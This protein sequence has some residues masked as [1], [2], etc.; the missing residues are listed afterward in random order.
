[1]RSFYEK[2][3]IFFSGMESILFYGIATRV[4]NAITATTS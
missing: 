2:L 3:K 4:T 1:M